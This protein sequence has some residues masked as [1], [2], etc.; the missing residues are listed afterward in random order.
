M[1][2]RYGTQKVEIVTKGSDYASGVQKVELTSS[3]H[4]SL[5]LSTNFD[6]V[7]GTKGV[8]SSTNYGTLVSEYPLGS[9]SNATFK[10][11]VSGLYV[12]SVTARPTAVTQVNSNLRVGVNR[13]ATSTDL[14]DILLSSSYGT[15]FYSGQSLVKLDKDTVVEFWFNALKENITLQAGSNINIV[16]LSTI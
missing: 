9:S 3:P 12:V 14:F 2:Y 16:L 8:V 1:N 7:M 4:C 5:R 13:N 6:L 11:P 15:G 10:V